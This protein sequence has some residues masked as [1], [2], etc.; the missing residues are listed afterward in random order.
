MM[1]SRHPRAGRRVRADR[2]AMLLHRRLDG[3]IVVMYPPTAFHPGLDVADVHR[4][5][6]HQIGVMSRPDR[7]AR[8]IG[9]EAEIRWVPVR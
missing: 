2:V 1:S 5:Q 4:H 7:P 6:M 9:I 3:R 8:R